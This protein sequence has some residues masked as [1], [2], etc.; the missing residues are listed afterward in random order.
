LEIIAKRL[1]PYGKTKLIRVPYYDP[2]TFI[3]S[4]RL[5]PDDRALNSFNEID[6]VFKVKYNNIV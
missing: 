5:K 4:D 2:K 6:P 1:I 3:E